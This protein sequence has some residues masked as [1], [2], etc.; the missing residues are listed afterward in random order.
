MKSALC[1]EFEI[2][3]LQYQRQKLLIVNYK[4]RD[5]GEFRVDLLVEDN[6]IVEL[7]S[8]RAA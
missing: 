6:V 5:I 2:R 7:K 1:I 4:N 8:C 3:N